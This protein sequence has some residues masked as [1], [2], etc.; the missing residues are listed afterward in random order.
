MPRTFSVTSRRVSASSIQYGP[1]V[2][3]GESTQL[4]A[5][6]ADGGIVARAAATARVP[7]TSAPRPA[8]PPVMT[9][10]RRSPLGGVGWVESLMAPIVGAPP[11]R[12]LGA[13]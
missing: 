1:S 8:A 11:E 13:A 7:R 6:R 4:A 12:R 5:M 2:I 3:S 9:S 10:R